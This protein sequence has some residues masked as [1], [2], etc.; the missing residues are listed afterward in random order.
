[1]A[2]TAHWGGRRC[3][4]N[5][6]G[7]LV[8]EETGVRAGA[9]GSQPSLQELLQGGELILGR[10]SAVMVVAEFWR[11]KAGGSSRF[12]WGGHSDV[13]GGGPLVKEGRGG[14]VGGEDVGL[15]VGHPPRER[16]L[17]GENRI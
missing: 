6:G 14:A 13:V 11:K 15:I 1:M 16:D 4:V 17:S 8:T 3:F 7:D 12:E 9:P 10:P 2:R 5:E